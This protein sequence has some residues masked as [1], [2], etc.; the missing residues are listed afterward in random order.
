MRRSVLIAGMNDEENQYTRFAADAWLDWEHMAEVRAGHVP[1]KHDAVI[2]AAAIASHSLY[3]AVK[4]A[5]NQM[6]KPIFL[7]KVG[8][9]EIRE[10]F[11][12]WMFGDKATIAKLR[13]APGNGEPAMPITL[14][15]GW[16]LSNFL[17]VGDQV[18]LK[19]IHRFFDKFMNIGLEKAVAQ[20]WYKAREL[21]WLTEL[22]AGKCVFNGIPESIYHGIAQHGLDCPKENVMKPAIKAKSSFK[23][24]S[25]PT[26]VVECETEK[27]EQVVEPEPIKARHDEHDHSATTDLLLEAISKSQDEVRALREMIEKTVPELIQREMRGVTVLLGSLVP[28]LQGLSPE[29]VIKVD[30]MLDLFLSMR[31]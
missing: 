7:S 9:S 28:K 12:L 2:V 20:A 18:K 21:G 13:Q 15:F 27:A 22:S 17:Q 11:D 5:Y 4:S 6:G 25:F 8:I 23:E 16:L 19:D 30:Q 10:D 14:R 26:Y 29:Q 24:A 31:S 1:T 3:Q